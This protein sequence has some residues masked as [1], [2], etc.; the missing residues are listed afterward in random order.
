MIEATMA[1]YVNDCTIE[2]KRERSIALVRYACWEKRAPLRVGPDE[3][4]SYD[5]DFS[6]ATLGNIVEAYR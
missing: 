5:T 1:I 6:G 4:M 3:N 2:G